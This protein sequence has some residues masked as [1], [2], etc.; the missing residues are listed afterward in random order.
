MANQIPDPRTLN[1]WEDAFQYP[2]P[3]VRKLE[4][5]LRKNIDENR[6]KLRSLVGASYRDLLG[7]AEKI[8]EMDEQMQ[9][10]E[11]HLGDIGRKC[12]ARA[13]ERASENLA[14]M[15]TAL[16]G[17]DGER[18]GTMAQTKVLQSTL[19]L[20][21][22]TIKAGGDALLVSKLLVLAR[23][24]HKSVS[25]SANPPAILDD[26]RRRLASLRRK[27][28]SY[29]ER[30]LV[31]STTERTSLAHALCAYSL[32]SSSAPKDVLRHFLQARFEQLEASAET[33]SE[34]SVLAT[35]ELYKRTLLDTR[36]LFPRLFAEAL[37]QLSN[38]P[39]LQDK[40]VVSLYELNL[41]I[42][43]TWIAEDVR[44]FTPWVRHEQ[45]VT[46]EVTNGLAS[47]AKQAQ[48]A[49]LAAAKDCVYLTND[50]HAVLDLR[51][52][53]MSQYLGLSSSV[54]DGNH[55]EAIGDLRNMFMSRLEELAADCAHSGKNSLSIVDGSSQQPTDL[56]SL[57]VSDI[58]MQ[59]GAARFRQDV[60]DGR[61]G[62]NAQVQASVKKLDEWTSRLN[63][64]WDLT[65]LM[66][67]MKW[68]DELDLDFDD[69]SD[70]A[71]VQEDLS[72]VDPQRLQDKFRAITSQA[73]QEM[74]D[75]V[76]QQAASELQAALLIRLLREIDQRHLAIADRFGISASEISSSE[77]VAI[78]HRRIAETTS[79]AAVQRY[80]SSLQK[81]LPAAVALWDGSPP[82]PVQPSVTT[83]KLLT[84]LHQAMSDAGN[85]LWTP[86]AVNTLKSLLGEKLA[87]VLGSS[88]PANVVEG[89][90][91]TNGHATS[92]DE[93]PNGVDKAATQER[94]NDDL[95]RQKLL[96]L[97]FDAL[98]LRCIMSSRRGSTQDPAGL[99]T[100]VSSTKGRLALDDAASARLKKSATEYWKRTYLLFGLLAP[101]ST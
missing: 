66:R 40:Q 47:W 36:A 65:L 59:G 84:S 85:D 45:L 87:N 42:Y 25:E 26:L 29:V 63:S 7:T 14:R 6:Q 89:A 38:V 72:K 48:V 74:Y 76:Q 13:V 60:V 81:R 73:L 96:Q 80:I 86:G 46:S 50:A 58:D 88:L 51:K 77:T 98:Y 99:Q 64:F 57:A 95:Q 27:L 75:W 4:Q 44:A 78:L 68:V 18:N 41:D 71:P 32:V 69:V 1:S 16:S 12:N 21:S 39:L 93:A 90:P 30:A 31:K 101:A 37:S 83:F 53:V 70:G 91:L 33:P 100:F 10:V 67:S 94:S 19:S 62:R 79:Q 97:T 43:G 49:V 28:L 2:L 35:L 9:A 22:R 20:A 23:L 54:R 17:R 52:K 55:L 61:R 34:A 11:G 82:L 24:L 15:K 3:V 8:I 56:W 92:E 5:Q